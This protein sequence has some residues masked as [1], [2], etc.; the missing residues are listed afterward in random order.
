MRRF[1]QHGMTM[2]EMLIA[3]AILGIVLLVTSSAIIQAL[4]VNRLAEDATNTQSKLRRITEVI[5]QELRSAVLGG[6]TN[7]PVNT[8]GSSIS[9]AL[10]SGDGGLPV[11]ESPGQSWHNSVVTYVYAS[12][13]QARQDLVGAPAVIINGRGEAVVIDQITGAPGHDMVQHVNCQIPIDYTPN[14]RIYSASA[15]GFEYDIDAQT[16]FQV[17]YDRHGESRV[18]FAFGLAG[19]DIAYEYDG[20]AGN[21]AVRST[22]YVDGNGVPQ[23]R[24]EVAG[25]TY[26][27]ARLRV[28]L[29]SEADGERTPREYVAYIELTGIGNDAQG[30]RF[31]NEVVPCN[32]NGGGNNGGGNNGGGN[33]G[34]GN[35]GGGNNGGGNNGGGNNGGGNNGG[36]NDG[37]GNG[38][39][40]NGGGNNGGGNNG[41]GNG[42]GNDGCGK[43]RGC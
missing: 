32:Q 40:D 31:V 9:F 18:P 19:F 25:V 13:D 42:G 3:M 39:G 11:F 24:Y 7:Y 33:N 12:D 41:G 15:L 38:G 1:R 23:P 21:V 2:V 4:Q 10:L 43:W 14:T 26:D 28:T 17:T 20:G 29:A 36:G 35:N 8:S 6:L 5:S 16:L 27:L 37:G 22:P 30:P 34:G